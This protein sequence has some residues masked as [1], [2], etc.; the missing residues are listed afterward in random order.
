MLMPKVYEIE[1][2]NVD[3]SPRHEHVLATD[4][5]EAFQKAQKILATYQKEIPEA[6]ITEIIWECDVE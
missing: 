6:E 4:F 5:K 2:A 3:L 1:I